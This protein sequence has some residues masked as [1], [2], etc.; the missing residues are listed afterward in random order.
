[1]IMEILLSQR[2]LDADR[3]GEK[4]EMYQRLFDESGDNFYLDL[5]QSAKT[6]QFNLLRR[7]FSSI[8]DVTHNGTVVSQAPIRGQGVKG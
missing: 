6:I 5:A 1:M 8:P 3:L 4:A 7:F 2:I